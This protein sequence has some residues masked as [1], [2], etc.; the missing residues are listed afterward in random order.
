MCFGL[1]LRIK[2]VESFRNLCKINRI[3]R[4]LQVAFLDRSDCRVC[5][6]ANDLLIVLASLVI[7]GRNFD[8]VNA[9]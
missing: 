6:T 8:G 9:L 7:E 4:L 2:H 3:A 1:R 5:P